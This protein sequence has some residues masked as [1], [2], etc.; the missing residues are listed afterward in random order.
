MTFTSY[1]PS[2]LFLLQ[3]SDG[4]CWHLPT[5]QS[6]Q[7]MLTT[8]SAQVQMT[9]TFAN[10]HNYI[11]DLIGRDLR[12][13][14]AHPMNVVQ[15]W[16]TNRQGGS[17][18]IFTGY[19]DGVHRIS[20][21]AQGEMVQ[22]SCS[23]S[24][25]LLEVTK[26]QPGDV[27]SLAIAYTNNVA[28]SSVLQYAARA[29]G[30]PLGADSQGAPWL[31][32]DPSADSGSGYQTVQASLMASPD[33]QTWMAPIQALMANAGL[34][35]FAAEDGRWIWRPYGYLG[36][37]QTPRVIRQDDIIHVELV[38]SDDNIA[39]RVQ[40]RWAYEGSYTDAGTWQAP[41]SMEAHLGVRLVVFD[42]QWIT[43][44]AAAAWLAQSLGQQ[45]AAGVLAGQ[46]T[47]PADP[48]ITVGSI[49]DV[50]TLRRNGSALYYVVSVMYQLDWAGSWVMTCGL[51]Y[52]RARNKIFPYIDH[53]L[54]LQRE[55]GRSRIKETERAG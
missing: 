32:I 38:E 39:T 16:T 17:R 46:V 42:A 41:A 45:Y 31:A 34:E 22:L 51:G 37:G 2:Y 53:Y 27:L 36:T 12:S 15:A 55:V 4:T 29:V 14:G 43:N 11:T 24:L 54:V 19:I 23:S 40:V 50:P 28:A 35:F 18:P 9:A 26:Q 25:K 7:A 49:V 10:P 5:L 21:P 52:G 30:F 48:L 13:G 1:S 20:D 8:T 6:L 44:K 33:L 47:I 3:K